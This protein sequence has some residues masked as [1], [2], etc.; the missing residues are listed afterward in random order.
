MTLTVYGSVW[1]K[2]MSTVGFLCFGG[3]VQDEL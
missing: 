2:D 3:V 1:T